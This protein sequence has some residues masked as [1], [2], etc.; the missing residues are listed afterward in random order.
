MATVTDQFCGTSERYENTGPMEQYARTRY[1]LDWVGSGKRVLELGCSTGYMSRLLVRQQCRVVGIEQD[2]SAAIRAREFCDRVIV[3]DL[4]ESHS[5]DDVGDSFDVILIGDVLEHLIHP[6]RLMRNLGVLL[7]PGGCLVIS[8]PNVVHWRTRF[9]ILSGHFDYQSEGTLDCTH[10]RFFSL[11]SARALIETNGY[12]ISEFRGSV[13]G[14]GPRQVRALF[15]LLANLFPGL[16]AY[17]LLFQ[18][19][20][21]T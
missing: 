17:Q 4:N 2:A 14:R 10:L 15:Q 8:L 7:N 9:K 6:D 13:S 5:L 20:P 11:R 21:I 1:L 19:V 12:R 18:A 16:F 3:A